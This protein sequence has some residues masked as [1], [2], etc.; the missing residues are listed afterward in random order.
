MWTS[1]LLA[2]QPD[3]NGR[4]GLNGIAEWWE[5]AYMNACDGVDVNKKH[6]IFLLLERV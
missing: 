4:L 6:D 1:P 5:T 2:S 3:R